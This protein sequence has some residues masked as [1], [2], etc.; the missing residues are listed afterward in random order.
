MLGYQGH[1]Q[2]R[3]WWSKGRD[4]VVLNSFVFLEEKEAA[5]RFRRKEEKATPD[6]NMKIHFFLNCYFWFWSLALLHI[7]K[8]GPTRGKGPFIV[9]HTGCW[10]IDQ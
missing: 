5:L 9:Y 6:Q 3:S 4:R 10:C 7:G 8:K 2:Q 1:R